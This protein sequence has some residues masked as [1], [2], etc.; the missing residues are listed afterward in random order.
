MRSEVKKMT[1]LVIGLE[2]VFFPSIVTTIIPVAL[3]GYASEKI[4][5]NTSSVTD[6]CII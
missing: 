3:R 4:V 5:Q 2:A 1:K 6:F